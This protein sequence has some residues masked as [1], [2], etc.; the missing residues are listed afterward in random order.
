MTGR[1]SPH[2]PCAAAARAAALRAP[3]PA[4]AR[5]PP[6]HS[7]RPLFRPGRGACRSGQPRAQ[8]FLLPCFLAFLPA[9]V[10]RCAL[11]PRL[12]RAPAPL[13]SGPALPG[14]S[15]LLSSDRAT[16]CR[17]TLRPWRVCV[18]LLL[19]LRLSPMRPDLS[20]FNSPRLKSRC[21][22]LGCGLSVLPT[23]THTAFFS[24]VT[25]IYVCQSLVR[26]AI[27]M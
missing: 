19:S 25:Q 21:S 6:I 8:R 5:P 3:G 18:S 13:L 4:W 10:L 9:P 2:A 22:I 7:R 27:G 11:T 12:L 14:P 15:P 23:H 24:I 20:T 16:I 26:V 1:S 17:D